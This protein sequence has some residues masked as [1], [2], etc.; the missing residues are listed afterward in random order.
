MQRRMLCVLV[1]LVLL[2]VRAELPNPSLTRVS[3]I[4]LAQAHLGIFYR[5]VAWVPF[6]TAK[7]IEVLLIKV[8]CCRASRLLTALL[9]NGWWALL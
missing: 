6:C 3:S 4:K 9:T 8:V 5:T 1:L 2:S 7:P